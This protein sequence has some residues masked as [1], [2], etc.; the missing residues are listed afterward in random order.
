M[1]RRELQ[2]ARMETAQFRGELN[3]S[4]NPVQQAAP[5][6][7][8]QSAQPAAG[9]YGSD[10]YANTNRTELPPLRSIHNGPDS[11]TGVQYDAPRVN[12]Y[13]QERY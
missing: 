3:A 9:S 4:N 6:P 2:A 11:M 13:R 7:P 8:S 1:L 10:P 5:P 12:G